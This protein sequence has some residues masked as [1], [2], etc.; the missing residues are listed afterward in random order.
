MLLENKCINN[1]VTNDLKKKTC[2][3]KER[4]EKQGGG[5]RTGEGEWLIGAHP[6]N[7]CTLPLNCNNTTQDM[8]KVRKTLIYEGKS[9]QGAY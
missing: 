3:I 9:A 5:G 2:K 8:K 4:R 6:Q 7:I 1:G